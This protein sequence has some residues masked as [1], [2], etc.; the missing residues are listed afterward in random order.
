M[1][2]NDIIKSQEETAHKKLI[3]EWL[4]NNEITICEP[5]AV[6]E[7]IEYTFGAKKKKK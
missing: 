4:S 3:D 2:N 7:N 1:T 5:N 6:T